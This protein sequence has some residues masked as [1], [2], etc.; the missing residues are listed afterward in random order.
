MKKIPFIHR[1]RETSSGVV[2]PHDS[3]RPFRLW[4]TGSLAVV[5]AAVMPVRGV[6]PAE[7]S[8]MMRL[9][10][11]SQYSVSETVSRLE[12]SA[13]D[14]GLPVLALLR[15]DQP[16][17]VLASRLGG[18]PVL[19]QN[20]DSSPSMPLSLTIAAGGSGGADVLAV[21]FGTAP[22]SGA[23]TEWPD[24]VAADLAELPQL[25]DRA[26]V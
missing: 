17:L 1:L 5:M 26:L 25:V 4:M 19:M 18:T 11:H 16:V 6:S 22:V 15:G 9:L 14:A 21:E 12:A 20:A 2:V 10:R 13:R 8:Q 23:W 3:R 7:R 24:A